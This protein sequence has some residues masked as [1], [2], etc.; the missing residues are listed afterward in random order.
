MTL[1]DLKELFIKWYDKIKIYYMPINMYR[2]I[3][4]RK[5]CT[6]SINI[7]YIPI[8]YI[9]LCYIYTIYTTLEGYIQS[10]FFRPY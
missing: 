3:T 1:K 6:P 10:F 7:C 4:L 9:N 8:Q 2:K 5:N